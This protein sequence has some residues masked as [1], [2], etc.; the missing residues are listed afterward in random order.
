ML[1][2]NPIAN[3]SFPVLGRGDKTTCFDAR[4]VTHNDVTMN[5]AAWS[6]N[7]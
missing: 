3:G 4:V 1:D 2:G 6:I 7:Y 5:V